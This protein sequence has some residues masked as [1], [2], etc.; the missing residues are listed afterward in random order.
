[1]RRI[2]VH[3]FNGRRAIRVMI[4]NHMRLVANA[5]S[6]ANQSTQSL[7]PFVGAGAN[8]FATGALATPL[9]ACF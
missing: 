9:N 2:V 6:L 5:S 7:T 8:V 4:R 3:A 1:M